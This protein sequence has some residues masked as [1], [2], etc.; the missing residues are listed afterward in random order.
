[1]SPAA[2]IFNILNFLTFFLL[3]FLVSLDRIAK[4]SKAALLDKG[5]LFGERT[6]SAE[7]LFTELIV[8]TFSFFNLIGFFSIKLKALE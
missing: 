7:T 8:E 5:L 6:F 4:P 3:K 2:I 1:M